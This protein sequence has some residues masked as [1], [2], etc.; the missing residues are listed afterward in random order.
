MKISTQVYA[1]GSLD[2]VELYCRAFGLEKGFAVKNEAGTEYMHCELMKDGELFMAVSEAP[3]ECDTSPKTKWQT[4][5]F[6]V[7]GM[8][9]EAAVR[10]AYDHLKEGGSVIDPPGP[11]DWNAY[12]SNV[13]DCYGVFWWIAI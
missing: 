1:A 2:A 10:Q 13:I 11:C 9:S 3:K 8:G 6:N 7:Y 5:A 4:V 12:C